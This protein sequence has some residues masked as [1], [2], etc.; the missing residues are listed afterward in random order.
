MELTVNFAFNAWEIKNTKDSRLNK[1]E[2]ILVQSK[3]V[4]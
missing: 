4:I 3:N 2:F 1:F